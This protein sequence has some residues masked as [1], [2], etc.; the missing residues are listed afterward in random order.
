MVKGGRAEMTIGMKGNIKQAKIRRSPRYP[1][2]DLERAVIRARELWAAVGANETSVPDA[3]KIW[4]Y[5]PKSSGGVQT[6]AAVKQFG[7][8]DVLGRGKE[9]RLKLA[10]LAIRVV[11]EPEP[12]PGEL[13]NLIERAALSPKI[14]RDL[15]DR[16]R[17]S[18]PAE[19]ARI[20]L[21]QNRGFQEKGAEAVLAE[22]RKTVS[23]LDTL[24][25]NRNVERHSLLNQPGHAAPAGPRPGSTAAAQGE[26][27][28]DLRFEGNQLILSARVGRE[29]IPNLIKILRAN[30]ALI[31]RTEKRAKKTAKRGKRRT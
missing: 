15:W 19:E 1:F 18:P 31:G 2:V 7:L 6:E 11:G 16:W 3:W 25:P 22:Y 29:E 21:V 4:G 23:F 12:G 9:R 28:V 8:I 24:P 5:G 30:Q 20:Y 14:H 27:F 13:R 10:Q 17:N 26:N